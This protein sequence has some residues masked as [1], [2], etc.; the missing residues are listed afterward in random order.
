MNTIKKYKV[1]KFIILAVAALVSIIITTVIALQTSCL[2]LPSLS[3]LVIILLRPVVSL[4]QNRSAKKAGKEIPN[5]KWYDW[6]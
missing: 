1:Q 4:F 2:Y 5:T 3:V 6:I